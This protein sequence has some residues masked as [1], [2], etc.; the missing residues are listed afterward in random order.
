MYPRL[1]SSADADIK[2]TASGT[3]S[4]SPS[5]TPTDTV[6]SAESDL[7]KEYSGPGAQ[8]VQMG[9]P[10]DVVTYALSKLPGKG[11]FSICDFLV[12]N[13]SICSF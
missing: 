13:F 8:F 4:T 3:L 6:D 2:S 10:L 9:F 11:A 12:L 1:D 7:A 5:D